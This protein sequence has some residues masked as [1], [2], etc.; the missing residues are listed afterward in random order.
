MRPV[1]ETYS[2]SEAP[3]VH[4]RAINGDTQITSFFVSN[5]HLKIFFKIIRII[6]GFEI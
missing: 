4:N 6:C 3:S 2:N 5:L 1:Y